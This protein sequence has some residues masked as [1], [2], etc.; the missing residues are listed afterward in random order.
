MRTRETHCLV[1]VMQS[2]K[3]LKKLYR[4]HEKLKYFLFRSLDGISLVSRLKPLPAVCECNCNCP[5]LV[6]PATAAAAGAKAGTAATGAVAGTAVVLP[7]LFLAVALS[8]TLLL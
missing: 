1:R 3:G 6:C 4:S 8:T 5:A 7:K 2:R